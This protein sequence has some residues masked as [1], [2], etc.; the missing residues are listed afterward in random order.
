MRT[1]LGNGGWRGSKRGELTGRKNWGLANDSSHC[2]NKLS[3]LL[4]ATIISSDLSGR[5]S[6]TE[7]GLGTG[8]FGF[9]FTPAAEGHNTSPSN[10]SEE[11]P[12][13]RSGADIFA[14]NSPIKGTETDARL[15]P[16][17][18]TGISILSDVVLS[19]GFMVTSPI[20]KQIWTRTVTRSNNL[21]FV[22]LR[23]LSCDIL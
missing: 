7:V 15:P 6:S 11:K 1:S 13:C 23:R 4:A 18:S 10:S 2:T 21:G 5:I 9:G 19:S 14:R 12:A 16:L 22:A 17:E 8:N 3:T 20:V